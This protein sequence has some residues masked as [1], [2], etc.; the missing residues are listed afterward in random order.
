MESKEVKDFLE[1]NKDNP[2]IGELRKS[3]MPKVEDAMS[4]PV[5]QK[6]MKS[7]ADAEASRQ[8]EAFKKNTLPLTI[9]EEV[10][11]RIEASSKKTPEQIK[12]EEYE[13]KLN[14]LTNTLK[15]KERAELIQRN[16]NSA[17]KH[18]TEKK[19]PVDILDFLVSDEE[20]KTNKNLELYSKMME[21]YETSIRQSF[22]KNNNTFV[23]PKNKETIGGDSI[24]E[25]GP[26]ASKAEWKVYWDKKNKK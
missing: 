22:I 1:A 3:L 5:F 2:E 21:N 9:E 7:F 8:I 16:K 13:R 20:D 15:E 17:L 10:K 23:P 4:D 14:E 19:Y 6:A 12:F 25:P 24:P 18:L 11:K 26:N